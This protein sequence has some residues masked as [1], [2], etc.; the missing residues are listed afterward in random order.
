MRGKALHTGD[1]KG[2]WIYVV[3]R[4][5]IYVMGLFILALGVALTVKS[6]LGVGPGNLVAYSLS[7]I[8]KIELGNM[9]TYVFL[10]YVLIQIF[11]LRRHFGIKNILQIP[12]SI[13]YGKFITFW[14]AALSF[15]ILESYAQRLLCIV[16]S[17]LIAGFGLTLF[18][19]VD[20]VAM[21]AEGLLLAVQFY[22]KNWKFSTLKVIYDSSCTVFAIVITWMFLGHITGVRE[23]SIFSALCLGIVVG[24]YQKHISSLINKI[25]FPAEY[26]PVKRNRQK[27]DEKA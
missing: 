8:W 2:S 17:V 4:G 19:Q 27:E 1:K 26:R 23:G 7:L 9:S 22:K 20:I 3:R 15:L 6:D 14:N 10:I 18:L 11:I 5:L 25:C 21:P 16:L 12:F 24:L 13:I